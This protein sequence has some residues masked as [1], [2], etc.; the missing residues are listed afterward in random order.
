VWSSVWIASRLMPDSVGGVFGR[1][2]V[3]GVDGGCL[4]LFLILSVCT[5]ETKLEQFNIF[6]VE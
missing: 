1:M 3:W 4:W 6:E 2:D 5:F